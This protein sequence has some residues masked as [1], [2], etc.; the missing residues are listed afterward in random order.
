[1]APSFSGVWKLQPKS[2]YNSAFPIDLNTLPKT[3]IAGGYTGADAF[4]NV[5]AQINISKK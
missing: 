5:V 3:L 1:M 2:Q 4:T